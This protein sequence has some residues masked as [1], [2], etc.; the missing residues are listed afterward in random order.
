MNFLGQDIAISFFRVIA[1]TSVSYLAGI[2]IGYW[3]Y[4]HRGIR[5]LLMPLVNFFRHI[6]PFCWLPI[7]ILVAGIG[8]W[9]VGIVLLFSMLFNAIVISMGVFRMVHRDLLDTASLDGA[10]R[11]QIFRHIL[12]P[13][14]LPELLNLFR[15]LWSVGWTAIIAAEMLGVRSGLGYRLLDFRYLLQYRE[16]LIYIGI[17]GAIGIFTD[18]ILVRAH[19]LL[20]TYL[21]GQLD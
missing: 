2:A 21:L 7:I 9:P 8:E 5:I 15:I 10:D 16:M 20:K 19:K 12:L 4:A 18:Y 14:S 17:I 13:L 6:S 11:K 1:W 3:C